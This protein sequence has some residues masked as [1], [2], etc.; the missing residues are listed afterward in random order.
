[1]DGCMDGY[2]CLYGMDIYIYSMIT[3]YIKW[4]L[5]KY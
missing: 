1:M 5:Y 4:Q 3:I 2:W